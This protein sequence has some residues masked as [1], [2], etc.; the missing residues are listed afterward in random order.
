MEQSNFGLPEKKPLLALGFDPA[1]AAF[2]LRAQ[3]ADKPCSILT[4]TKRFLRYPFPLRLTEAG[5]SSILLRP[6]EFFR[7]RAWLQTVEQVSDGWLSVRMDEAA[8]AVRQAQT[9]PPGFL[10]RFTAENGS[11]TLTCTPPERAAMLAEKDWFLFGDAL[12]HIELGFAVSASLRG[13]VTGATLAALIVNELPALAA[14]GIRADCPYRYDPVPNLRI[15]VAEVGES[16]TLFREH[17]A[18]LRPLAGTAYGWDGTTL[19]LLED[20]SWL[21][22]VFAPGGEARL[23]GEDIL[24][25]AEQARG[26]WAQNL[27]GDVEALLRRYTVYEEPELVLHAYTV[28]RNGIGKAYARPEV[29]AEGMRFPAY[30]LSLCVK[31]NAS[32]VRAGEGWFSI[33]SLEKLGL[34]RMGRLI[35]GRPVKNPF[36]LSA[37]ELLARGGPRLAG[38]WKRMAIE[39]FR[40]DRQETEALAHLRFLARWGLN[41]G[42]K[43]GGSGENIAALRG[44][45]GE[46]FLRAPACRIMVVAKQERMGELSGAFR[47][48][49]PLRLDE[50]GREPALPP[51]RGCLVL[52]SV[53][54]LVKN[55]LP[56]PEQYDLLVMVEPDA[57]TRSVRSRIFTVLCG[58]RATL[59]I[60]LYGDTPLRY[61]ALEA[62]AILLGQTSALEDWLMIDPNKPY[63]TLPDPY[64]LEQKPLPRPATFAEIDMAGP[65]QRGA[66][67][68]PRG[69]QPSAAAPAHP[70]ESRAMDRRFVEQARKYEDKTVSR[71]AFVPF[72]SYWP[73]Y[74]VMDEL[75]RKWYFYWRDRVRSGEY[76]KTD[77]S[78]IFVYTY[79]L[80]NLVGCKDAPDGYSKLM[81]VYLHYREAHPALDRYLNAWISD[82]ALAYRVAL[83]KGETNA[84]SLLR[85]I[86]DPDR[87]LYDRLREKPVRLGLPLIA[88]VSEYDV[89]S[90]AF[91]Q[92][93]GE[94][95]CREHIPRVVALVDAYLEKTQGRRLV[96]LFFP[97]VM[98]RERALFQNAMYAG[99]VTAV[100]VDVVPLS[101]HKPLREFMKQVV[102]CAEN[103]LREISGYKGKLRGIELE[104]DIA[105]LI[106]SYLDRALIKK[107]A[108]PQREIAIDPEKLS[109]AAAEAEETLRMLS[110]EN[111]ELPDA[112]EIPDPPAL[113]RPASPAAAGGGQE[114]EPGA[115]RALLGAL[116]PQ[117]RSIVRSMA[118]GADEKELQ[119]VALSLG[120]LLEP[121]FEH[122]NERAMEIT[123]DLLIE[124]GKLIE[125][126]GEQVRQAF[127]AED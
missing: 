31:P 26:A 56:V 99:P 42:L 17:G 92:K 18:A 15:R 109:R 33:D 123:G 28:E 84:F 38:P 94:A 83:T 95:L 96:E 29:W 39:D 58:I 71:A 1:R 7:V 125:E 44:L 110:V 64:P 122:I 11:D 80:I 57:M 63:P 41:G 4:L 77:L 118:D 111:E 82:F 62:H 113:E 78:Y 24:R 48:F 74:W 105:R 65:V 68:P 40:P 116:P 50:D 3:Y 21:N 126:Y 86:T 22:G 117:E 88:L 5:A 119:S 61:A 45:F 14:Q 66:P 37:G 124:D 85:G 10:L 55:L 59:R 93:Q 20:D 9:P 81:D 23:F 106:E 97:G 35:D 36:A 32:F 49:S 98:Q 16:V 108:Q 107:P 73:S 30:E 87:L 6:P 12:F 101:T 60:G 53:G 70:P 51:G 27:S 102:R 120:A 75:Q 54:E 25:F 79:E 127:P 115:W 52:A 121:A 104:A 89:R 72:S 67:I 76:P 34:G 2:F 8:R 100:R 47:A 46:L 13:P 90:S 69:Q 91:Y 112:E 43:N 103:K 19:R 114:E